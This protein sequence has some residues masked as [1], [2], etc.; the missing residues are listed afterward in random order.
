MVKLIAFVLAFGLVVISMLGMQS[1]LEDR[2]ASKMEKAQMLQSLNQVDAKLKATQ[3][4]AAVPKPVAKAPAKATQVP[5]TLCQEKG[6]LTGALAWAKQQGVDVSIAP[7]TKGCD[8]KVTI[9]R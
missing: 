9:P 1:L 3:I 6:S 7:N 4:T 5:A 2:H 8:I